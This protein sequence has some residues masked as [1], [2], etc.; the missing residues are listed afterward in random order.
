MGRFKTAVIEV[1]HAYFD[2]F[3][4]MLKGPLPWP[5]SFFRPDNK[6]GFFALR[7]KPLAY[8]VGHVIGYIVLALIWAILVYLHVKVFAFFGISL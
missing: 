1:T 6:D 8:W 7:K 3:V 4:E 2:I 5:V